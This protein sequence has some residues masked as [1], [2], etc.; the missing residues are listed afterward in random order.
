[1]DRNDNIFIEAKSS[2]ETV[3]GFV[4]VMTRNFSE[5][6]Q[7]ARKALANIL[8]VEVEPNLR[9]NVC[10]KEKLTDALNNLLNASQ[11]KKVATAIRL[12]ALRTS[13]TAISNERIVEAVEKWRA[14]IRKQTGR[15][16]SYALTFGQIRLVGALV[17]IL[18]TTQSANYLFRFSKVNKKTGDVA[19]DV[20]ELAIAAASELNLLTALPKE[21]LELL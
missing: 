20:K 10:E 7:D 21:L 19:I 6:L 12:K 3:G 1:M 13:L 18:G 2:G 4:H 15:Q 8:E 17:A 16:P 14:F 9:L 5:E 11:I